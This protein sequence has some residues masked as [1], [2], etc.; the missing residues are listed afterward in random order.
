MALHPSLPEPSLEPSLD[1]TKASQTFSRTFGTLSGTS[2]SLTR[3]VHQCTPDLLWVEN[4]IGLCCWGFTQENFDTE[5][6][7]TQTAHYTETFTRRNFRTERFTQ[8]ILYL[9][10][11]LHRHFYTDIF[12]NTETNYTETCAHRTLLHTASFYAERLCFPFLITYLSFSLSQVQLGVSSVASVCPCALRFS[13]DT[14]QHVQKAMRALHYS[15][16]IS[17]DKTILFN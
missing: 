10:Q 13:I 5:K 16:Y 12:I 4:L 2:L 17:C 9:Q 3:R 1:G 8:K 6:L 7:S 11:C 14:E 15:K